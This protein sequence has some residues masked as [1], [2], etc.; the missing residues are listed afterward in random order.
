MNVRDNYLVECLAVVNANDGADHFWDDDHVSQMR[1]NDGWLFIWWSLL[2]GLTQLLDQS[3][4]LAF[5]TAR[6]TPAGTAVHEFNQ[7]VTVR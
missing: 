2:L 6:K 7:L 1:L 3:H 5:Q 4:W